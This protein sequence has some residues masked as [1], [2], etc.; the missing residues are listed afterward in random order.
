[1][2]DAGI[3]GYGPIES[4]AEPEPNVPVTSNLNEDVTPAAKPAVAQTATEHV[5]VM[6]AVFGF[7]LCIWAG[8]VTPD[9]AGEIAAGVALLASHGLPVSVQTS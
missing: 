5:R 4:Q 9:I 6:V 2:S 3:P 1:M 8:N 7:K